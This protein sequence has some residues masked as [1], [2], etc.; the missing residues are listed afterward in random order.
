[1]FRRDFIQRIAVGGAAGIAAAG[2]A[3]ATDAAV[4][5][6]KITGFSCVTCAVGLEVMLRQQ[7]GVL[8]AKAS[9]PDAKVVIAYDPQLITEA[10]IVAFIA[11]KGFKAEKRTA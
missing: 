10:L 8:R 11:D 9:Y 3:P 7:K 5:T 4:V 6:Y 1:M 2:A